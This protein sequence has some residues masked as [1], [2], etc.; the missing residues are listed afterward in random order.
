VERTQITVAN[1]A[2]TNRPD[3][4][5]PEILAPGGSFDS[6]KA[7]VRGGANAVYIG[8]DRFSARAYAANFTLENLP[9][10]IDFCRQNSLKC[11]IAMNTAL[12]E[13]DLKPF[14]KYA[15][16]AADSGADALILQDPGAARLLRDNGIDIPL[17][18]STQL[19]IHSLYGVKWAKKAGFCRVVLARES[20]RE[21]IREIT[22]AAH[23][24][25]VETEIFV[26]GALCV[27]FSGQCYMSALIGGNRGRNVRS[28][29]SGSCAGAC[30]LPFCAGNKFRS[31]TYDLSLRDLSLLPHIREIAEMGVDS[32]KIEGRMKGSEYVFE[33]VTAVKSALSGGKVNTRKLIEYAHGGFTDEYYTVSQRSAKP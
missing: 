26:H 17:H 25:D 29:N 24:M 28:A 7:A 14:V 9:A 13:D 11:Y 23:E 33:T 5:Q 19:S 16:T 8:L 12:H 22:Q 27:S 15:K 4:I 32:L 10:V 21:S 6:V 3:A 18:A 31:N 1:R 20:D 2:V 30:R